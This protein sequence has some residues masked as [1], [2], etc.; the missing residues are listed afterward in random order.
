MHTYNVSLSLTSTDNRLEELS[1]NRG[2]LS[3]AAGLS[4]SSRPPRELAKVEL[5]VVRFASDVE[6]DEQDDDD[7]DDEQ[8][9]DDVVVEVVLVVDDEAACKVAGVIAVVLER[10]S[11]VVTFGGGDD[12]VVACGDDDADE[13]SNG[14][15]SPIRV[16]ASFVR[17]I[18]TV[19]DDTGGNGES[20][21]LLDDDLRWRLAS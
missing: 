18:V 8:D 21:D 9:D 19:L 6:D 17:T 2:L 15:L 20:S 4:L 10:R 3:V 16:G 1:R 5:L 11:R 13:V 14:V 12:L 7:D